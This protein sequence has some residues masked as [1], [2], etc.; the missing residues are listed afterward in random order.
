MEITK[1]D[2]KIEHQSNIISNHLIYMEFR[3]K[4]REVNRHKN[5]FK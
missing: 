2:I 4:R 3:T 1:I 5:I